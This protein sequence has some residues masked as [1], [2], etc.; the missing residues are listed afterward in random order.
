MANGRRTRQHQGQLRGDRDSAR[1]YADAALA[2]SNE[3][4]LAFYGAM[5]R[6]VRG[7]TRIES[8]HAAEAIAEM[9][10]GLDDWAATGARLMRPHF[11]AL[12]SEAF[13]A[14]VGDD[15]G[16]RVL[17]EALALA[18]ETGER[19]YEAELHRLKA[20]RLAMRGGES[21]VEAE[22]CFSLALEIARRQGARS[23]ELRAS[24]SL[25]R[26]HLMNGES[27]RAREILQPI[28]ESLAFAETADT[29]DG[30]SA[31]SLLNEARR[32]R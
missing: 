19:S 4:D 32:S 26:F 13:D 28:C 15:E 16:R 22:A 17:D 27:R 3:H 9:R 18:E 2:L 10:E 21:H 25:A 6:V 23:L 1:E 11:L 29:V 5:A 14:S 20:E 7:W 8:G 30:R 12:L 24:V 31:L